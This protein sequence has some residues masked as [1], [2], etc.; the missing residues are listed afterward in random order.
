MIYRGQAL[1][2]SFVWL[3]PR[4]SPFS[5]L[6]LSLSSC[7]SPVSSLLTG[8]GG[9]VYR[10]RPIIRQRESLVLYKSLNSLSAGAVISILLSIFK[11]TFAHYQ[12]FADSETWLL[13]TNILQQDHI[14][15]TRRKVYE[16]ARPSRESRT[17]VLV[18]EGLWER[19]R[20]EG[21]GWPSGL[22]WLT[23]GR[24]AWS[25]QSDTCPLMG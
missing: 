10:R 8:Q 6:S 25:G 1:S 15:N 20:P 9:G 5:K 2:P 12:E 23:V 7:V 17:I 21:R 22:E 13:A 24:P 16:R 18:T 3:L 4:P 11:D 14:C 19:I